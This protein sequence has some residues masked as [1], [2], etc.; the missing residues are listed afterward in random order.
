MG[1]IRRN[2]SDA[3]CCTALF[4]DSFQ[5]TLEPGK[6]TILC[7]MPKKFKGVNTKAEAARER[8][9]AAKSAADEK[10]RRE[11]ED[12]YWRDDDKH[13][14]RKEQRKVA[15]IQFNCSLPSATSYSHSVLMHYE[16]NLISVEFIHLM[17]S[18]HTG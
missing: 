17:R 18:Q 8:K 14:A 2:I 3:I 1:I 6:E 10:K 12:E 16:V 4:P 9:Q 11:E 5:P 7:S 15:A 13:V